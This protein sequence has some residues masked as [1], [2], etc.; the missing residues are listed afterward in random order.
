MVLKRGAFI[1]FEGIDRSGK[2]T[3]AKLLVKTLQEK[4]YKTAFMRFPDRTTDV[5]TI[6]DSFLR[7]SKDLDDR[8]IHLLYSANRWECLKT[9]KDHIE[10]GTTVICDRYAFSG[11]A[12][13]AAKGIDLSWCKSSDSGLPA[14]D[15]VLFMK[16]K[17]KD[18]VTRGDFGDE[19]YERTDF[20]Q[21]IY[22]VYG[23]LRDER[24]VDVDAVGSVETVAD[25]VLALAETIISTAPAEPLASLEW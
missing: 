11:V 19:R 25:R 3:Q 16:M 24:W 14:P 18:A 17:V 12:Y 2:T 10:N 9:L 4:G 13:T 15:A 21:K 20:Q 7:K 5:G 23:K 6:I 22:E 1:V 8:C